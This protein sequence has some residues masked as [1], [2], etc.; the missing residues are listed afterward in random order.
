MATN[1][2]KSLQVFTGQ[3]PNMV[4]K[5]NS[6]VTHSNELELVSWAYTLISTLTAAQNNIIYN[7]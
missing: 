4:N 3:I 2:I 5:A 1:I 7:Y 6:S